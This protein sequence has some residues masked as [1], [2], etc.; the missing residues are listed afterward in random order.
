M[1]GVISNGFE[2]R[3]FSTVGNVVSVN[4]VWQLGHQ[5]STWPVLLAASLSMVASAK[6]PGGRDVAG[7][8]LHHAAAVRRAAH[9]VVGDA[10]RIHDVEREQRNVR[11]LEH[12]AAGVED[13]VRN[14]IR[15]AVAAGLLAQPREHLV[16]ELHLGNVRDLARDLAKSFDPVAALRG[17]LVIVPRHHHPR[18]VEHEARIDAVVAGLD[19]FAGEHA[20]VRPL[21]RR[22]RAVTAFSECR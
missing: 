18:H 20:G 1:N 19:A 22:F 14:R 2:P 10:E 13:E 4:W 15:R 17:R 11:G 9:H 3:V 5:D 8:H 6:R 21:A 16:A 12:V 7:A